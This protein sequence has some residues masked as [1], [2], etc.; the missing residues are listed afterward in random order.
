MV[1]HKRLQ[2]TNSISSY[3]KLYIHV[4]YNA[5]IIIGHSMWT[6]SCPS[7]WID[8]PNGWRNQW[9]A[10]KKKWRCWNR[11][12]FQTCSIRKH[13]VSHGAKGFGAVIT[14]HQEWDSGVLLPWFFGTQDC[15][16]GRTA[17]SF[18]F[19]AGQRVLSRASV[20]YPQLKVHSWWLHV[21]INLMKIR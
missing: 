15:T 14:T 5:C 2:C 6:E 19:T 13:L 1:G 4:V 12:H 20:G 11:W 21:V 7:G 18:N 10:G 3:N 8:Q 17:Q 16:G 9:M